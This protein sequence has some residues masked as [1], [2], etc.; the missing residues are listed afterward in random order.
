MRVRSWAVPL[1]MALTS[2]VAACGLT[3]GPTATALTIYTARSTAISKNVITAFEAADPGYKGRVRVL[4]LGAAE[5][6]ERVRAESHRPQADVWWGGT[7]QAFDQ[8]AQAGLLSPADTGVIDRVPRQFR[9]QGDLWL[10]EMR[11][12]NL[13]FY[14]NT[15]LGAAQAP[16]D[17]DDLV[18]PDRKGKL[19]IR[20]VAASGTMRS[21]Y[22]A[23]IG[24]SYA[25][26]GNPRQGYQFLRALDRNTAT[27]AANPDDL[28][29]RIERQEAPISVWD[30]QDI[31]VQR[32]K[33]A[34]FT[35]VVPA[36]GAMM[37]LDGV[38]RIKNGPHGAAADAFLEFLLRPSTQ[39]MLA[40][41]SFQLPTVPLPR[42][43]AWL[44]GTDL[45]EMPVDWATVNSHEDEWIDYWIQNIK[46][47]S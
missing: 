34:H 24:R 4:T 10:G 29:L 1:L 26:T 46:D 33:G 39:Q 44:S 17:W 6:A 41:R 31:L 8:A 27:Y 42:N 3:S 13:I 11:T 5:L 36:S 37:Q 23:L 2:V 15:M 19:L 18:A 22:A 47:R 38:A 35:P 45:R 43:P 40:D 14:N 16:K 28:Y 20:D 9:G 7:P 21:V 12:V 30:L 25:R 32:A